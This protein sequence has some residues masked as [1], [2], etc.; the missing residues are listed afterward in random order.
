MKLRT[1]YISHCDKLHCC[2]IL[3]TVHGTL[4]VQ[5]KYTM[6][7]SNEYGEELHC[8]CVWLIGVNHLMASSYAVKG[9]CCDHTDTSK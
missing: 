6:H 1:R 4:H 8:W 9:Q 3:I 2:A 5:V 7:A